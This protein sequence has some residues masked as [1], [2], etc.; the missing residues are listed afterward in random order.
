MKEYITSYKDEG[1]EFSAFLYE[2]L[3]R[4]KDKLAKKLESAEHPAKLA[5]V[6]E[7]VEQYQNKKI[8]RKAISEII[9]IQS[10]V[11]ELDN[12]N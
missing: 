5:L 9:K 3:S 7:K 10:L 11:D 2:E 8:D 12:G 4:I 1:L 6:L